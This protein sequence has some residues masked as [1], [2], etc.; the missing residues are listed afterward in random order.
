[1]LSIEFNRQNKEKVKEAAKNKNREVNLEKILELDD[2]RLE[3]THK[4]Q[5]LREERNQ[6]AKKP[7]SAQNNQGFVRGRKIKEELKKIE[8]Q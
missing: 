5:K 6:I 3:L 8:G 1:M 4:I 2:L 7:H